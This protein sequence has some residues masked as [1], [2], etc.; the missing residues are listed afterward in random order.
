MPRQPLVVACLAS[1]LGVAA[2]HAAAQAAATADSRTHLS[3]AQIAEQVFQPI[4]AGEWIPFQVQEDV[5]RRG[6][7][8]GRESEAGDNRQQFIL[9]GAGVTSGKLDPRLLP[10]TLI[11]LRRAACRLPRQGNG[12]DGQ[13]GE[14]GNAVRC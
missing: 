13:I 11:R 5:T 12:H 6:L 1:A 10:N 14:R 7:R 3:Q 8:K 9:D 2:T 4:L